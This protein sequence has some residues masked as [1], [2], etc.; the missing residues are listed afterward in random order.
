MFNIEILTL[1]VNLLTSL[2]HVQ[3][4]VNLTELYIRNNNILDLGEIFYLKKLKKLRILWLADNECANRI[5]YR[6]TVLRNLPNLHKLD[7]TAVTVDEIDISQREGDLFEEPP[8]PLPPPPLTDQHSTMFDSLQ[9]SDQANQCI[10]P[11]A[12]VKLSNE[13]SGEV[14]VH[15][16]EESIK[17]DINSS[18]CLTS[19]ELNNTTVDIYNETITETSID[20]S[21]LV[22]MLKQGNTLHDADDEISA[23]ATKQNTVELTVNIHE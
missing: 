7:N 20:T 14:V 3:H 4:C 12:E 2:E 8:K 17:A 6:Q 16:F 10:L 1:S 18:T 15:H 13:K 21:K 22:E 11:L 5:N 19:L 9:F 23:A